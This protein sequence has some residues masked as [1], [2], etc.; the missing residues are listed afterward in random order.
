LR[1]EA[2]GRDARMPGLAIGIVTDNQDPNGQGRV[3]VRYPC[4]SADNASDWAR[5]AAPGNGPDRGMQFV[6]EVND[7]VLVGFEQGDIH[8][9][10]VLGGLWNG[11]DAPPR[12]TS[13]VVSSGRVQQRIIKSRSGHTITLDDSDDQPSITIV[14][15]TGKNTIKLDSSNNNLSVSVD[16]DVALKA[17]GTIS[18]EGQ[19]VQVKATNDLKLTGTSADLEAQ[20]GLTLKG[21]TADLQASGMATVKGATVSFN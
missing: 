5:V 7:E 10:Y 17:Q 2:D 4:L 9:P 13:Q 16:G 8:H 11:Q 20:G 6:P 15:K 12:K 18:I 3:K 14:D 21:A 1:N 19:S